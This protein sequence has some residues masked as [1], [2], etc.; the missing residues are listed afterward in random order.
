MRRKIFTYMVSI[1]LCLILLPFNTQ[2]KAD[3][4]VQYL[5]ASGMSQTV[6]TY[7]TIHTGMSA[8]GS[9][10]S[11]KWYVVEGEVSINSRLN[12]NGDVHLILLDDS[13]LVV[14]GGVEVNSNNSLTV[15]SQSLDKDAMGRLEA[16]ATSGAGIGGEFRESN[17]TIT[18]N[19]GYIVAKGGINEAN[20]GAGIGAGGRADSVKSIIINNG[21]V[22]AYGG[23]CGDSTQELDRNGA[24]AGIGAGGWSSNVSD[25]EINGGE[26]HAY[27]GYNGAAGIGGG[28]HDGTLSNIT[29]TGG[30]IYAQGTY[31]HGYVNSGKANAIGGGAGKQSADRSSFTNAI[32]IDD[33]N[34]EISIHG[35][36]NGI[37]HLSEDLTIPAGYRF[38]IYGELIVDEGYT[39]TNEGTIDHTYGGIISGNFINNGSIEHVLNTAESVD[40]HNH[41]GVCACGETVSLPHQFE[42][43]KDGS[44]FIETCSICNYQNITT[45][46]ELTYNSLDNSLFSTI[47]NTGGPKMELE[48]KWQKYKKDVVSTTPGVEAENEDNYA[49]TFS[50]Q[51]VPEDG[52][53]AVQVYKN[54]QDEPGISE[55]N[56]IGIVSWR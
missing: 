9:S 36:E 5:D 37:R 41:I 42:F 21:Y 24:G 26:I 20:G 3:T 16:T 52:A 47:A 17:G 1:A 49:A 11:T 34:K 32:I 44:Q 2:V 48:Y 50:F 55:S 31:K 10:G 43:K 19:G 13:S 53:V 14:N 30:L 38:Y 33:V 39:L 4:S 28:G 6:E 40:E 12:I 46:G 27:A 29:V 22:E 45:V 35:D 7:E 25:I 18:I 51:N 54:G 56:S 15:Y 23:Y 8:L